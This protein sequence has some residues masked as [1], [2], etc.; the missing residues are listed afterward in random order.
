MLPSRLRQ[1]V[2]L[3]LP[4]RTLAQLQ[5]SCL[6]RALG[7][8]LAGHTN[9]HPHNTVSIEQRLHEGCLN[10]AVWL[11]SVGHIRFRQLLY[12][13]Q[14]LHTGSSTTRAPQ[15][16]D[17]HIWFDL[18]NCVGIA[19]AILWDSSSA[20]VKR[21][22]IDISNLSDLLDNVTVLCKHMS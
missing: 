20:T 19:N 1:P 7:L 5:G 18:V 12:C 8:D 13:M 6:G 9:I 21:C 3:P 14:C 15:Q 2:H 10:R 4:D 11:K 17:N 16:T 22:D